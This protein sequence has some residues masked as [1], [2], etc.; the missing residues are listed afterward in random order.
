MFG[1]NIRLCVSFH[2]RGP[3][4]QGNHVYLV[5]AASFCWSKT[6]AF[7]SVRNKF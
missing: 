2:L 5:K 3:P 4:V 1:C 6:T 7:V